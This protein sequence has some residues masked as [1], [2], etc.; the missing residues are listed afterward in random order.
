MDGR[1]GSLPNK[2]FKLLIFWIFSLAALAV[3][4]INFKLA[5]QQTRQQCP[6]STDDVWRGEIAAEKV[7]DYLQWTN[8]DAC[9]MIN[10][11]GG[12]IGRRRANPQNSIGEQASDKVV[13]VSGLDGHYAVCFDPVP[14][15]PHPDHCVAYSFGIKNDWTYDDTMVRYGCHVFSFDPSIGRTAFE[16]NPKNH[17][18]DTALDDEDRGPKNLTLASI[19]DRMVGR[20]G[21]VPIDHVKI[22]IEGGEWRILPQIIRSGMLDKIKQLAVEVHLEPNAPHPDYFRRMAGVVRSL[23]EAGMVRFDSYYN[24][25][26]HTRFPALDGRVGYYAYI[27]AWYNSKY[28]VAV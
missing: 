21:Q 25:W 4:L 23:E 15:A 27:M 16:R 11:F 5:H 13:P 6:S 20:H 3:L 9:P 19:Y 14:V 1:F 24:F 8:R 28:T 17:F 22:D 10:Y 7:L 26:T 2:N 18:Y 12:M